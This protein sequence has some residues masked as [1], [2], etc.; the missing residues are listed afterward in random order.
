MPRQ[1]QNPFVGR[2]LLDFF[3][4]T[5]SMK[6]KL[7]E[8]IVPVV[9][10]ADLADTPNAPQ[11]EATFVMFVPGS[12]LGP[13]TALLENSSV[14]SVFLVDEITITSAAAVTWQIILTSTAPTNAIAGG[15]AD[16]TWN[17]VLQTPTVPGTMFADSGAFVGPDVWKG[18]TLAA[19]PTVIRPKL[20]LQPGQ[21]VGITNLVLNEEVRTVLKVRVVRAVPGP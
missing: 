11:E 7:D 3:R 2:S 12:A 15:A 16:K 8:T 21:M 1:T 18:R 4:M 19:Q 17:D 20:I 14:G 5:G 6:L 13:E 9:L 10:L